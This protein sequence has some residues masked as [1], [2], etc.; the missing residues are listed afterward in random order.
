MPVEEVE[1]E[2]ADGDVAG[3]HDDFS[4]RLREER[5]HA[6]EQELVGRVEADDALGH[7]DSD[8]IHPDHREEE[9][10]ATP[11][12]HVNQPVEEREQREG[13]S[14]RD[15]HEAR[16][17][18]LLVDREDGGQREA[19]RQA[20]GPDAQERERLAPRRRQSAAPDD[21]ACEHPQHGRDDGRE[22]AGEPL[23]IVERPVDVA[24]GQR[25]V[26]PA[27]EVA[28]RRERIDREWRARRGHEHRHRRGRREDPG[29]ETDSRLDAKNEIEPRGDRPG[30]ADPPEHAPNPE[31]LEV[32]LEHPVADQAQQHQQHAAL[33]RLERDGRA[34]E[35]ALATLRAGEREADAGHEEEKRED[36]VHELEAV[37]LHVAEDRA[38]SGVP[39]RCGDGDDELLPAHDEQHVEAPQRVQRHQ[40]R[41]RGPLRRFRRFACIH[42]SLPSAPLP[43]PATSCHWGLV[44][45]E[46]FRL[47]SH[48]RQAEMPI[49]QKPLYYSMF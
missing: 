37:P 19:G 30:D 46:R 3:S 9:R 42:R 5:C 39:Q 23:G 27:A 11:A 8:G 47:P 21:F 25:A 26:E 43:A 31:V 24:A 2:P 36:D 10:R 13:D 41:H 15:Q 22:E 35:P 17:P 28:F 49:P 45:F 38:E 33:Q 29:R 16:R 1:E 14:A 44:V 48:S 40:P 20:D 4:P 6:G 32:E 34:A 12:A 7:V 18:E